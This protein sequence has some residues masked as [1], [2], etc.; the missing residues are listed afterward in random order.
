MNQE[1]KRVNVDDFGNSFLAVLNESRDPDLI[2][3]DAQVRFMLDGMPHG[4]ANMD[5]EMLKLFGVL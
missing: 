4:V 1:Y 2:D 5:D 3:I